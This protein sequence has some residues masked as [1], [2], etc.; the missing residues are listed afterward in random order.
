MLPGT[1]WSPISQDGEKLNKVVGTL[2][3]MSCG[4]VDNTFTPSTH[5]QF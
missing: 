2:L 4:E 1:K 3:G 5:I